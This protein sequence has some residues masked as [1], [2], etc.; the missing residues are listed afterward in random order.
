MV[1]FLQAFF[2][3]FALILPAL[4]QLLPHSTLDR[5]LWVRARL[6]AQ[7]TFST[8]GCYATK[9]FSKL[10]HLF[11][12]C[13]VPSDYSW[14]WH[15]QES[16]VYARTTHIGFRSAAQLY[17]GSTGQTIHRREL[18]RRRKLIQLSRDRIAYYEPALKIWHHQGNFYQ[19]VCIVLQQ[20]SDTER[21]L[22]LESSL[23]R[24]YQPILNAPWVG[25]LLSRL[26]LHEPKFVLPAPTA[27]I[28]FVRRAHRHARY[29]HGGFALSSENLTSSS[30]ICASLYRLG[31][32]TKKKFEEA[33]LLR[34]RDTPLTALYLRARFLKFV[35]EPWQTR[36]RKYLQNVLRYRKGDLPPRNTSLILLPT[37]HD[38]RTEVRLLIRSIIR[39]ER[40]NFPPLHLPSDKLILKKGQPLTQLV[41][42]YRS[43]MKNWSRNASVKCTCI[44]FHAKCRDT[45]IMS[46][47]LMCAAADVIP[48][49][50]LAVLATANL[51]DTTYFSGDKWRAAT[52]RTL[53]NWLPRWV[54]RQ[55]ELH[56]QTVQ[57]S[58]HKTW[59]PPRL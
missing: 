47:H 44:G 24:N 41:F 54:D 55:W 6:F 37:A 33:K 32:N 49:S 20:T 13:Q 42:N 11:H 58:S 3:W 43:F 19:G 17:A 36:A 2:R 38:L 15:T 52:L 25:Q 26:R 50:C 27:G 1:R 29:R 23:I 9:F 31:S 57:T 46:G 16:V 14:E 28:R 21:R 45:A 18:A 4:F 12:A 7:A 48:L 51:A 8:K 39:V 59:D 35:D 40:C 56:Q 22:A 53:R 30:E 10:R 34:S 5:F